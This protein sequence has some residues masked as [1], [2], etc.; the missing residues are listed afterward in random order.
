M[1]PY[2]DPAACTDFTSGFADVRNHDFGVSDRKGRR[3]GAR[4]T[5][6]IRIYSTVAPGVGHYNVKPGVYFA[7]HTTAT[8][9]GEPFGPSFNFSIY[10]TSEERDAA[11]AKYLKAAEARARKTAAKE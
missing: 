7:L 2:I 9:D 5:L 1:K 11:I 10:P 3:V 6:T 4:L 8:R